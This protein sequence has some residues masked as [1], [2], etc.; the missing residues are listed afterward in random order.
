MSWFFRMLAIASLLFCYS[1]I[2]DGPIPT[3]F[4]KRPEVAV[5]KV[6]P[7]Q[8]MCL[9]SAIWHEARGEPIEGQRAVHDVVL[10]RAKAR[11]LSICQ[12]VMQPMQFS[13]VKDSL[14]S[15][16]HPAKIIASVKDVE[17]IG[18]CAM[19]FHAVYVNPSWARQKEYIS[20][21]GQHRFYKEKDCQST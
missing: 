16:K 11:R 12:V 5:V 1:T 10:N 6:P 14:P 18:P 21:I 4:P 2:T 9:A 15:V 20:T 3:Y 19:Y 7:K 17:S 13:F 8:E